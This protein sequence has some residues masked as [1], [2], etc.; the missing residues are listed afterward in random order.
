MHRTDFE[1]VA[2]VFNETRPDH[3]AGTTNYSQGKWLQWREDVFTM[4]C[5]LNR[6]NHLFDWDRFFAACG[7]ERD[8]E[9]Q[10]TV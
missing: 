8:Y 7:Y 5:K 2:S 3:L 9:L 1:I 4:A 6:E 10:R